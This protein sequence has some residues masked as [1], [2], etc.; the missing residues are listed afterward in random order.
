MTAIIALCGADDGFRALNALLLEK[1]GYFQYT[2]CNWLYAQSKST[3]RI[4][5]KKFLRRICCRELLLITSS[6]IKKPFQG[7]ASSKLILVVTV[8][9]CFANSTACCF[10]NL[11][12]LFCSY[13]K[14]TILGPEKQ[15]SRWCQGFLKFANSGLKHSSGPYTQYPKIYYF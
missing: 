11:L 5:I 3:K 14:L 6:F 9:S 8:N 13:M 4:Y 12:C 15:V 7:Y 10:Y 1:I 2:S